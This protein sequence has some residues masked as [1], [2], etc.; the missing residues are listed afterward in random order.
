MVHQARYGA[1][2]GASAGMFLRCEIARLVRGT[3]LVMSENGKP[4]CR[5]LAPDGSLR[6]IPVH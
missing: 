3:K 6:D 4:I 1:E 2:R 5:A